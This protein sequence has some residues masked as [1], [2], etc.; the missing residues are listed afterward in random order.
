MLKPVTFPGP[1]TVSVTPEGALVAIQTARPDDPLLPR[2]VRSLMVSRRGYGWASTR[3]TSYAL[4]GLTAYLDHTKELATPSSAQI[5]VNG[6]GFGPFALDPRAKDP[7]RTVS[8]PRA[9]LGDKPI[10][11][12][13]RAT[14]KVYRT[15]ALAGFET[16]PKLEAKATDHGLTV[17]R[18][19]FLMEPRRASNGE[20]R[21]L[22]SLQPVTEF[23]NGDVVRVEL[24]IHSDV[25]RDYVL[26]EEPTPSSCRVTE[27]T[28]LDQYEAKTWWWSRTVVLDDHLAFFARSLP[29]GESKIVYHMRAEA[30][31]KACALP[32]RAANMYV[33]VRWASTAETRVEVSR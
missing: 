17:E 1:C 22:P 16:T 21:L 2:I 10:H 9:E 32:A 6:R 27:R 13:V 5:F 29:K 4:V 25:P 7:T 18:K 24:T 26:V 19:T 3:D 11:I 31:G 28:E 23:K 33:P 12:E 20:M 8:V 30:A 15:V 14:G